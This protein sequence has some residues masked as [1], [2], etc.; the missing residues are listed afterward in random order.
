MID[1]MGRPTPTG[2]VIVQCLSGGL[3][4]I[5]LSAVEHHRVGNQH[6]RRCTVQIV[7]RVN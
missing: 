3:G 2:T 6:W 5:S 7:A 1:T 4:Q